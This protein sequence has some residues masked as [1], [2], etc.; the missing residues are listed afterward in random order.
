MSRAVCQQIRQGLSAPVAQFAVQA[1]EVFGPGRPALQFQCAHAS[2]PSTDSSPNSRPSA[3]SIVRIF[4]VVS[5]SS[6]TGSDPS[7]TPA[8]AYKVTLSAVTSA[9]RMVTAHSPSPLAPV[10]PTSPVNRP[11]SEE[12]TSELQSQS[13]L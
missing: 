4:A 7:T 10:Q 12:H 1:G 5:A 11:R 9:Q 8:P 3:L 2:A 13:N 6:S